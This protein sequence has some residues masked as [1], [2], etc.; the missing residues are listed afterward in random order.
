MSD[1]FFSLDIAMSQHNT[2]P[3]NKVFK[4]TMVENW[5]IVMIKPATLLVPV[6]LKQDPMLNKTPEAYISHQRE[7]QTKLFEINI[8]VV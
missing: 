8:E 6:L 2:I 3:Y 4:Q 5:H 1:D 7:S